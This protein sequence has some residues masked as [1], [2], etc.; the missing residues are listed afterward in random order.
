M[1]AKLIQGI[2]VTYVFLD[3]GISNIEKGNKPKAFY[4]FMMWFFYLVTL[5]YI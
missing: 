5:I 1:F 3:I 2:L 4:Y